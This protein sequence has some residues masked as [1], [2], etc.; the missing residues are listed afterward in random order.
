MLKAARR[1]RRRTSP[2]RERIFSRRRWRSWRERTTSFTAG[3]LNRRTPSVAP[4]SAPTA[5][6]H[7]VLAWEKSLAR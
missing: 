6:D 3:L 7:E 1:K 5:S 4:R 2:A